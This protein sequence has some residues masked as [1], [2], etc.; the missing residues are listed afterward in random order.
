MASGLEEGQRVVVSGQFLIDSEASLTGALDRLEASTARQSATPAGYEAS[1]R[2][3]ALSGETISIA[4]GPIADL[5]WPAMT[6]QFTLE[7]AHLAHGIGVGDQV[8]FRIRQEGSRYI[9]TAISKT[10]AQP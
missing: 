2:I 4:H 6:M 5:N 1:G 10:G 8:S 7:T 9:V 3:T